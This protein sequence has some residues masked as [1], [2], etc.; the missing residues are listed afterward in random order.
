MV[1]RIGRRK[2]VKLHLYLAEWREAKGLTQ[3]QLADRL[4]TTDVT[5]SRWET[6]KRSPDDPAK[7]AIAHA[8]D[9]EVRDLYRHPGRPS[10]D[11]LLRGQPKEVVE[12]AIRLI[13]AIRR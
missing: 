10:A 6:G 3:A 13:Q 8:L 4:D 1:T 9:I 5:V 12:Q 11:D 7:A 2:P